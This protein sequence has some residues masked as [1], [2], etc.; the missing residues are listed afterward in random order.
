M[1]LKVLALF[2]CTL[3]TLSLCGV[4][5]S[6]WSGKL[7][8][9]GTITMGRWKACVQIRQTLEGAFTNQS[10]GEDLKKPTDLIAIDAG[11][12]TRLKLT[13][14][15]KNCKSTNLTDIVV[16]DC[17][18]PHVAPREWAASL[19]SVR[20]INIATDNNPWDDVHFGYNLLTWKVGDL[21]PGMSAYLLIWIETLRNPMERYEPTGTEYG[22][23]PVLKITEGAA[24]IA[25]SP[26]KTL[27]A[28][29]EGITLRIG[30][31]NTTGC[32]RILTH[33]PD[34]TPW[35]EDNY[36]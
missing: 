18:E 26:F 4:A 30:E 12:P 11:F 36:P 20:W 19:G 16:T 13:I 25:I 29:T 1:R 34:S 7:S 5:Y 23:D 15:V 27:L 9:R 32:G 8:I 21:N 17:I 22:G 24:V 35:A 14:H 3:I 6:Q 33:L 2:T 31:Y 28:T 10:T